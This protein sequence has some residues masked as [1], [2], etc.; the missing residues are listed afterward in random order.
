VDRNKWVFKIKQKQDG[1]IDWYKVGLV[2]KGFD[3]LSGVDY[4][5]TFN[6]VTKL[7]TIRLVLALAVK[8]YWNIR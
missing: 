4:H 5:E 3:Q 8:F 6:P 1:S 7:I 2:A